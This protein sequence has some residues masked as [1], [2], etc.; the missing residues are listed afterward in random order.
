MLQSN[1][2]SQSSVNIRALSNIVKRIYL[3]A[4]DKSTPGFLMA[5]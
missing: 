1:I 2:G 4:S 3:R 5:L